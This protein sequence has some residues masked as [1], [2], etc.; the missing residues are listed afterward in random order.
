[1]IK[2]RSAPCLKMLRD[3]FEYHRDG[4][5]V[6]RKDLSSQRKQG[7]MVKGYIN[8]AGYW[9]VSYKGKQWLLHRLIYYYHTG[10]WPD[11]IDH[12]NRIK[13]DSRVENLRSANASL[14][15]HNKNML[16]NKNELGHTN[17]CK[18]K[19][20]TVNK[21]YEFFRVQIKRNGVKHEKEFKALKD[22]VAWRD[23]TY[24]NLGLCVWKGVRT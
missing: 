16:K 18:V 13:T 12:I 17:I 6:C 24:E 9:F 3:E 2:L 19:K 1:M 4:Y 23:S 7:D 10:E 22:A 20:K 8:N 5:F 21:V 14:N 11:Q 15:G